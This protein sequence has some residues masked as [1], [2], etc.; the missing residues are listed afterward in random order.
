[1]R[2]RSKSTDYDVICATE[3]PGLDFRSELGRYFLCECK[4]WA[5]PATVTTVVKFAA[6]LRSAKCRFGIIFSKKGITGEDRTVYAERELLKIFQ[7]DDLTILVLS[8]DD[9]QQ[10]AEGA[11]FLV[12]LRTMYEQTRLDLPKTSGAAD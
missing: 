1:M 7:H 4:D 2:V 5:K 9:L 6:V 11:N 10:I 8:Q 3:G 12:L